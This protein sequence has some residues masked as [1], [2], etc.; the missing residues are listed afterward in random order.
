MPGKGTKTGEDILKV[1][2]KRENS[3]GML[4]AKMWG[5]ERAWGRGGWK[6]EG[7]KGVKVDITVIM[8]FKDWKQALWQGH[9]IKGNFIGDTAFHIVDAQQI[10]VTWIHDYCITYFLHV[11]S[12]QF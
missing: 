4:N 2:H 1:V 3:K 10:H 5:S 9:N 8:L 7:E 11:G 12:K 6:W